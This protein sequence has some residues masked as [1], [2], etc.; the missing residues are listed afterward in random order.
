MYIKSSFSYGLKI[1]YRKIFEHSSQR[2]LG[3]NGE[4]VEQRGPVV[5][6]LRVLSELFYEIEWF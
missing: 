1:Q 6:L 2:C 3:H 4:G 5:S